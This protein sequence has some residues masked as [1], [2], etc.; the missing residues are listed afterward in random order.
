[1]VERPIANSASDVRMLRGVTSDCDDDVGF[2]LSGCCSRPEPE[3]GGRPR[4]SDDV[5]QYVRRRIVNGTLPAGK[6][7][8]PNQLAFELGINVRPVSEALLSLRAE[9]LLV[10]NPPRGFRVLEVTARDIADVANVHAFVGAELA[11]RAAENI[12]DE[13]LTSLRAIQDKSESACERGDLEC[14]VRLNREFHRLINVAADSPKLTQVMSGITRYAIESVF[15]TLS[16]WSKQSS[17]DHRRLIAAFARHDAARARV[18]MAKHS[19]IGMT[20][21]ADHLVARGVIADANSPAEAT[22]TL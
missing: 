1:M 12:T 9:G 10:D 16:G 19:T 18:A 11:A 7:L 21:L 22:G 17:R 5:A 14:S 4:H 2:W 15:P 20:P 6:H 8:R 3:A 13:Q